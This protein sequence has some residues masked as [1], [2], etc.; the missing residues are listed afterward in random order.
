[1]TNTVFEYKH[2]KFSCKIAGTI[3]VFFIDFLTTSA[4]HTCNPSMKINVNVGLFHSIF[5][6][7]EFKERNS[8][9]QIQ[10]NQFYWFYSFFKPINR[11]PHIFW[12]WNISIKNPCRIKCFA[13]KTSW[14]GSKIFTFYSVALKIH[15]DYYEFLIVNLGFGYILL[16]FSINVF[17][18]YW[19]ML[20]D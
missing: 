10:F 3:L 8:Q 9:T 15:F 14:N 5:F 4:Y 19:E 16:Y 20:I 13:G 18:I 12:T 2:N 17:L 6:L 11:F 7:N 1:M